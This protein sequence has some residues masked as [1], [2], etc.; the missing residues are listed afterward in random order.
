VAIGSG[1]DAVPSLTG[2]CGAPSTTAP[3][4]S[5]ASETAT[6]TATETASETATETASET[7]SETATETASET[8]TETASE[9]ATETAS[10]TGTETEYPGTSETATETEYPGTSFTVSYGTALPTGSSSPID[11]Y[12]TS[13]I[14][15]PTYNGTETDSAGPTAY[16]TY[17]STYTSSNV[18]THSGYETTDYVILT[19]T[20][21]P[22]NEGPSPSVTYAPK[23]T[24]TT[25][26]KV[27]QTYTVTQCPPTVTNCPIGHVT[28]EE[29]YTTLT[30]HPEAPVTTVVGLESIAPWGPGGVVHYPTTPVSEAHYTTTPASEAHYTTY[31]GGEAYYP[32]T[33][34][35]TSPSYVGSTA[36]TY[37]TASQIVTAGAGKV[38]S[39]VFAAGIVAAVA[40]IF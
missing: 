3:P 12:P 2:E 34:L 30:W 19:T 8:A 37:P 20:Y 21:C 22:G 28:T 4:S 14:L 35:A 9:T 25:T 32:T 16:P 17:T 38:K 18:R 27:R 15:Y 36:N 13:T 39:G 29:S 5:T 33:T 40:M 31:P 24:Y 7:A 1:P 26:Y 10:E 11:V 6:E 23:P